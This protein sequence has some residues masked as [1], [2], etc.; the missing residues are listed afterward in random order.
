[1]TQKEIFGKNIF[2]KRFT[3]QMVTKNLKCDNIISD[4]IEFKGER[5][6]HQKKQ[7]GYISESE[8]VQLSRKL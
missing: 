3:K 8:K 6:R 5:K 7:R 1:M 2:R 4:K